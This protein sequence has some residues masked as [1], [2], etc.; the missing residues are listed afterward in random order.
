MKKEKKTIIGI[1]A[2]HD[3]EDVNN[4]LARLLDELCIT[5]KKRLSKFHIVMTGGTFKRIVKGTKKTKIKPVKKYTRD[6]LIN[7]CGITK[8]PSRK[9]GGVTILSF[10]IA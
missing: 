1:L 2:S 3:N 10:L 8:L 7:E 9:K 6:I 4:S 5:N